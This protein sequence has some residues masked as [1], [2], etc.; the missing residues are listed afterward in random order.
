M[1]DVEGTIKDNTYS[2]GWLHTSF[3]HNDELLKA[4][5]AGEEIKIISEKGTFLQKSDVDNILKKIKEG[6][7]EK[8]QTRRWSA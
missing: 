1:F 6:S 7:L 2:D 4:A 8:K 3:I 5:K